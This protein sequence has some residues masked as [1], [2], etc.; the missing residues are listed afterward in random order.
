MNAISMAAFITEMEKI[1]DIHI[2]DSTH[3]IRSAGLFIG[4]E[5]DHDAK[6]M[7]LQK[8]LEK[9][10]SLNKSR[11]E[12]QKLFPDDYV[13]G[14]M[15]FDKTHSGKPTLHFRVGRAGGEG[16]SDFY[17]AVFS[18][19]MKRKTA[20]LLRNLGAPIRSS[21][22][23]MGKQLG[24]IAKDVKGVGKDA[25]T[26]PLAASREGLAETV[27]QVT[28]GPKFFRGLGGLGLAAQGAQTFS[29]AK[30]LAP[31]V[32]PTGA[33]RGRGERIGQL[34]GTTMGGFIGMKRGITGS[35][36]SSE[37]GRIGAGLIGRGV[38]RAI[39]AARGIKPPAPTS[40]L[41]D[42]SILNNPNALHNVGMRTFGSRG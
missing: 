40:I 6:A 19:A 15:H 38:D 24:G 31:S 9:H 27:K 13:T 20:G 41:N 36:V 16:Q 21:G 42:P 26:R 25:L 37:A 5:S 23:W 22:R 3:P 33:K 2:G 29:D 30:N 12:Y 1:A 7:V 28:T 34:A 32:D 4:T 18:E 8:L 35:L 17:N 10:K 11:A 14:A 39:G